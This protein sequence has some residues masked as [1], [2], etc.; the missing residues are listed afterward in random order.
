M[1]SGIYG[2]FGADDGSCLYVGQ[3]KDVEGRWKQHL[4]KLKRGKHRVD[5]QAWF[6][7]HDCDESALCFRLLEAC[8]DDAVSK[9]TLEIKWF[10]E[11]RPL[12]Y[13]QVPSISYHYDGPRPSYGSCDYYL[14][15]HS[16]CRVWFY[17]CKN[18]LKV[19]RSRR[20]HVHE[21]AYCSTACLEEDRR[22]LKTIDAADVLRMINYGCSLSE[23]GRMYG[24]TAKVVRDFI[25]QYGVIERK[26]IRSASPEESAER[27]LYSAHLRWHVRRGKPDVD[28]RLCIDHVG[29]DKTEL[30]SESTRR[31]S[32]KD[33]SAAIRGR[34][35][36]YCPSCMLLHKRLTSRFAAHVAYHVNRSK[37]LDD[38]LFCRQAVVNV[39]GWLGLTGLSLSEANAL[40]DSLRGD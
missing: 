4:S 12:F 30:V 20:K 26:R 34:G 28:C 33:C 36:K 32:A 24:T 18:C 23:I 3:S 11:L 5:L 21:H 22:V 19:F 39:D 25:D 13:G 10:N 14:K 35:V 9:N 6:D 1:T 7:E 15:N 16:F 31:C 2:I 27:G 38:C 17:H 29:F 40:Y 37:R 8:E